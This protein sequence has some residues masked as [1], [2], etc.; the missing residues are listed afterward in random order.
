MRTFI[1]VLSVTI[2]T[3]GVFA[4]GD[5]VGF[6]RTKVTTEDAP[7]LGSAKHISTEAGMDIAVIVVGVDRGRAVGAVP[8]GARLISAAGGGIKV[9]PEGAENVFAMA[10][11]AAA[12]GEFFDYLM[13]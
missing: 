1:D 6:D 3:A 10:L 8:A 13:R 9:A 7:V 12:D 11:T 5:L 4:A 2:T